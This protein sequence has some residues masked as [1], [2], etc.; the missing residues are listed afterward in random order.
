MTFFVGLNLKKS[1]LAKKVCLK[2]REDAIKDFYILEWK[3]NEKVL[4]S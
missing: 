3:D 4:T 2:L 1:P